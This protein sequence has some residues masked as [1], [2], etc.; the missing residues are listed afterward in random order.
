MPITLPLIVAGCLSASALVPSLASAGNGQIT[1]SGAVVAPTCSVAT[2]VIAMV[3]AAPYT[4][5]E[6]RRLTCA[7]SGNTSVTAPRS[8]ALTVVRL[9]S[10]VPD[11]VLKYFDDYVRADRSN[12]ADPVLLTQ[13]YE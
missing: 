7:T 4:V 8:Y 2:T 1:F 10:S 9:S 13:V 12:A 6:A 5:T 3:A 11:R